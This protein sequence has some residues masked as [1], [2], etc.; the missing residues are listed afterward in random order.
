MSEN[1]NAECG[2]AEF[3]NDGPRVIG[4]TGPIASGKSTVAAML[5]AWGAEVID[6]DQVYRSL[7]S[8]GSEL[9]RRITTKFGS[10]IVRADKEIDRAALGKI[11]FTDADAL[12][13]LDRLTHPAVVAEIRRRILRSTAPVVVIEAIKLVQSGLTAD[14]DTLWLVTADPEI[15]FQRLLARPGLDANEARDRMAASPDPMH[16]P[17]PFDV[18]IDNSGRLSETSRQVSAAWQSLV[19]RSN[20]VGRVSDVAQIGSEEDT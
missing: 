2:S 20:C 1:R 11:V 14:V 16:S 15:R 17:V 19:S 5:L 4:L 9:W 3:R 12:A 7:L 13:D 18:I 8:P 10:S 6:A